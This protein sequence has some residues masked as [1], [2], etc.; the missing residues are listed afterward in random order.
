MSIAKGLLKLANILQHGADEVLAEAQDTEYFDP[1]VEIIANAIKSLEESA[2]VIAE[3]GLILTPKTLE[4]LAAIAETLDASGDELLQKQASVLDEILLTIAA[5]KNALAEFKAQTAEELNRL[6][7]ELRAKQREEYY[8][9]KTRTA[10]DAQNRKEQVIKAFKDKVKRFKPMEASLSTRHCPDHPGVGLIRV[11]DSVYQCSLDKKIYNFETGYTTMKGNQ[12]PGGSVN[13]QMKDWGQRAVTNVPFNTRE[14]I[15]SRYTSETMDKLQ[16][17]AEDEW[18]TYVSLEDIKDKFPEAYWKLDTIDFFDV[19]NPEGTKFFIDVNDNLIAE[20]SRHIEGDLHAREEWVWDGEKWLELDNVA[21]GIEELR[22]QVGE[23]SGFEDES[24]ADDEYY[25]YLMSD[26]LNGEGPAT[27]FVV[28]QRA[29]EQVQGKRHSVM[30]KTN[31]NPED[32]ANDLYTVL[33]QMNALKEGDELPSQEMGKWVDTIDSK[34]HLDSTTDGPVSPF[35]VI[36]RA[37]KMAGS[38]DR[39]ELANALYETLVGH[40]W[41]VDEGSP[42]YAVN[43]ADCSDADD[44]DVWQRVEA[45]ELEDLFPEAYNG[46]LNKWEDMRNI[47]S[48]EVEQG[49]SDLAPFLQFESTDFVFSVRIDDMNVSNPVIRARLGVDGEDGPMEIRYEWNGN[50]WDAVG[51]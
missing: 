15:L 41:L 35:V 17:T 7:D 30:G 45:K 19:E 16:K 44:S 8:K 33:T 6:R 24:G 14:T 47:V 26:L 50:E 37:M 49:G 11:A 43:T 25:Q 38:A 28:I 46:F 39:S 40:G 27:P 36:S 34:F 23:D 32:I 22:Q 20:N 42:S 29:I 5:P 10:F 21:G 12:V 2:E 4:D 13:N 3:A 31:T 48:D 18:E 1:I 9:N 51:I